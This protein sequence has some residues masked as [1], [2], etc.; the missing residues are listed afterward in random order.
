VITLSRIEIYKGK[1]IKVYKIRF[2]L[3]EMGEVKIADECRSCGSKNLVPIISLGN[4]YVTG[5][6]SSEEEQ[7]MRVP[8]ELVLCDKQQGGC[9]LL[10]LKHTT[11]SEAMWG[12][13]YWYK[14]AINRMIREDLN[15]IASRAADIAKPKENDI[16]IDIGCNDGTLLGFYPNLGQTLVGFEPSKNVA[17]EAKAKGF[18]V[19]NNYFNAKNFEEQFPGKKAKI[20]TAIS[21]FYDLDEPNQFIEDIVS[22]LDKNGL[23]I[24]Q[25]N[26]LAG[27]LQQNAFD[28]ICHEHLEY[29]SLDSLNHLLNK[30]GLEV[31]DAELN[32]INGG[33]I[34]TYIRFKGSS[35]IQ[36][37]EARKRIKNIEETEEKL[38]LGNAQTYHDF[39][40]RINHIKKQLWDFIKQEQANGKV[41]AACGASTRGNTTLQYFDLTPKE[42]VSISDRNPDKWGKKTIGSLIPIISPE[43]MKKL[44]PDYQLVLIWHIFRGI[45]DDEKEF[46]NSG[47][48]FILPL[49]EFRVVGKEFFN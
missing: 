29:Y 5:F 35:V 8:L 46:V 43:E 10:Q 21:M 45:G 12:G 9:G 15:E 26:Y 31:F 38:N 39:A 4:L 42:I 30:H 27:M 2:L 19:I 11:P 18:H 3:N 1:H 48:K 41:I 47:G 44:K 40:A 17:A 23:F 16:L 33:S 6:V 28:N 14:S 24:I 25:Q 49:P 37:E 32:D 7:G 22:C 13:Q 36:T 34:R 20:I